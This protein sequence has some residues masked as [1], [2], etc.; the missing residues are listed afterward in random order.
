MDKSFLF[1]ALK[2]ALYRG[3]SIKITLKGVT[4]TVKII[5]YHESKII[6]TLPRQEV[7]LEDIVNIELFYNGNYKIL[8]RCTAVDE[9]YITLE[10]KNDVQYTTK[11]KNFRIPVFFTVI[12]DGQFRGT[13]VDFNVDRLVAV[14][15]YSNLKLRGESIKLKF[16]GK[17]D[18]MI[19][20]KI[21]SKRDEIFNL[22]RYII[23]FEESEENSKVQ[24]V[25]QTIVDYF[26]T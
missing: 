15:A 6:L 23:Q 11:R 19:S 16:M 21:I 22:E 12:I 4:E 25:F 14:V 2:M 20:V 24:S 13:L 18:I 8:G 5:D 10:V 9:K 17:N 3:N 26:K 7:Q 1:L